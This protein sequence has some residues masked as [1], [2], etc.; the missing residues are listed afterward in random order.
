MAKNEISAQL[1]FVAAHAFS[2]L[3]LRN[4]TSALTAMCYR[5]QAGCIRLPFCLY[6]HTVNTEL[7]WV[8][9]GN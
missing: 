9:H 8:T 7:K 6:L 5:A 4:K 3:A 2:R 1:L